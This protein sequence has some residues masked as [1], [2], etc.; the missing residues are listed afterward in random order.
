M[1]S[2]VVS[3]FRGRLT[4]A[5][6][7]VTAVSCGLLAIGT[8]L[9]TREHRVRQEAREAEQQSRLVRLQVPADIDLAAFEHLA[10]EFRERAGFETLVIASDTAFSSSPRLG[11]DDVP[12]A[13]RASGQAGA[14]RSATTAVEGTPFLVAGGATRSGTAEVYLFHDRT[15]LLDGLRSLRTALLVGWSAAVVLALLLGGLIAR[16]TLRPVARASQ[17]AQAIAD[18]LLETRIEQQRTDELG[19]L[20]ASFNRMAEALQEKIVA[21]SESA[22]RERRFTANVAHELRTPLAGMAATAGLLEE[23]LDVL[24]PTA[25]RP[26][27]LLVDDVHRLQGLV[28]ELLELARFDAG[29]ETVELE[30]LS[31]RDALAAAGHAWDDR[32]QVAVSVRGAPWVLAD[33]SRFRRVVG[34]LVANAL[35]HGQGR[36]VEVR[37][38]AVDGK[39]RIDVLDRGPGIAPDDLPRLFERFF[40]SDASRAAGGSGLGLAIARENVLLQGG[41]IEAANRDGG[42]ARFTIVLPEAPPPSDEEPPPAISRRSGSPHPARS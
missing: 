29:H 25:R 33:R 7:V 18:G 35:Q 31:V 24:P 22:T 38:E 4:L 16:R 26:A 23:E 40:K 6:V 15:D 5:F 21:L 39:V 32:V 34:N 9:G 30:P 10:R 42:G 37:A 11:P 17:A 13:L 19:E 12:R 36:E 20:A 3:R 41:S 1:R 2:V 27:E 8:Y 14:T 28:L